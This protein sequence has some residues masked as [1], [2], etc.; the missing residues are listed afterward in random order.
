MTA[1]DGH[2]NRRLAKK[3]RL[4]FR[5]S[6]S[7]AFQRGRDNR[8]PVTWGFRIGWVLPRDGGNGGSPG[9]TGDQAIPPWNAGDWVSKRLDRQAISKQPG[10]SEKR[11]Q[12]ETGED[13]GADSGKPEGVDQRLA[14]GFGGELAGFQEH[15][16]SGSPIDVFVLF[17]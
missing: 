2:R 6:G 7:V 5:A 16:H 4:P 13:Q 17:L 14:R 1:G 9:A 10:F 12:G 15:G 3:S 8:D 11:W